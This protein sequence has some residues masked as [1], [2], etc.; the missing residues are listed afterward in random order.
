MHVFVSEFVC[1]GGC[2]AV[3]PGGSLAREGAAMWQAIVA[4]CCSLSGVHVS[5]TWDRRMGDPPL[6]DPLLQQVDLHQVSGPGE[7]ADAFA[8]QADVADGTLLIAPEFDGILSRRARA[9][10]S[11]GGRLIGPNSAAINL[12][13]D[14]YLLA[15]ALAERKIPTIPTTLYDAA[16]FR[17][18]SASFPLVIKPRDGAGSQNTYRVENAAELARLRAEH[19]NSSFLANAIC[20]PYIAGQTLSV[21]LVIA[22]EGRQIVS[23]CPGEQR[24]SDDGRFR[25]LGGRVPA[26]AHFPHAIEAAARRACAIVGGLQ[27]YIGVDLIAPANAPDHPLVVE[28]NPRLTTSY[29][30]YRALYVGNLAE[31]ILFPERVP[32]APIWKPGPI[33]FEPST[34]SV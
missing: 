6:A 15:R 34:L 27:G 7:E 30:G 12:C 2:D 24:L 21:G 28:I 20:Q 32:A 29:L 26:H 11:R 19:A 13:T 4:D 25:Y 10:E 22:A 5:T 23:F 9:V 8:A 33:E 18:D 31:R 1:G 17:G 3:D 14:K 16:T